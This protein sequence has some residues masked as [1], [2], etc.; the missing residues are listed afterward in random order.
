MEQAKSSKQAKRRVAQYRSRASAKGSKR[1][2]VTVPNRDAILVKAIAGA[3][4]KGG[5]TAS[6]V[7]KSVQPLVSAPKAKTGAELVTFLR[8][9]PLVGAELSLERDRSSGR[10]VDFD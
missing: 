7:R 3:L 5:E 2:E 4:R 9:S 6:R 1:V 8:N 10:T